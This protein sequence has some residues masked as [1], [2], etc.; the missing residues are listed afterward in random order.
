MFVFR[1]QG[2]RVRLLEFKTKIKFNNT[3]SLNKF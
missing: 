3:K 1:R 2:L